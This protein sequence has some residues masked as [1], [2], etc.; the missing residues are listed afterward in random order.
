MP[1]ARFLTD[2]FSST[3][4]KAVDVDERVEHTPTNNQNMENVNVDT[5]LS[6]AKMMKTPSNVAGI[7]VRKRPNTVP[8]GECDAKYYC[9][10]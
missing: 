5:Q 2:Y 9:N 1:K 6:S 3:V 10:L 4:V 8:C 7:F